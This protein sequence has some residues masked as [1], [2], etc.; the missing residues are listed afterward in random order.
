MSTNYYVVKNGPSCQDPVH[1]GKYSGGWLFLFQA[2]NYKLD[3]LPIEWHTYKQV[4]D[5]LRKNTGKTKEYVIVDEYD[6]IVS[7]KDFVK[8]V[9][10]AQSD[11]DCLK[12]EDNFKYDVC[13]V[14][15]YRFLYGEFW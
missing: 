3:D 11:P 14:D 15:G 9:D 13:N 2:Q 6:R 8:M 12:N 7:Y 5:W 10:E 4:K 1:I